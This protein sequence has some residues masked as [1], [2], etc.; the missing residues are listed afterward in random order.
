MAGYVGELDKEIN[1]DYPGF[2]MRPA[3]RSRSE[4]EDHIPQEVGR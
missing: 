3:S 4:A 2:T 1:G